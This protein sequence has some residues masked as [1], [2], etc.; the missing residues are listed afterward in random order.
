MNDY[1]S[2]RSGESDDDVEDDDDVQVR[3]DLVDDDDVVERQAGGRGYGTVT[4][5]G[6]GLPG[7]YG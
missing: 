2:F 5:T 3:A 7:G 4:T 6:K 1:E